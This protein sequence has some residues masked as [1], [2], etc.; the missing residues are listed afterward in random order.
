MYY[1]R[2]SRTP[3]LRTAKHLTRKKSG[4]SQKREWSSFIGWC[5]TK[6]VRSSYG[7]T[8]DSHLVYP[9]P[10]PQC[11]GGLGQSPVVIRFN[12]DFGGIGL[13][14]YENPIHNRPKTTTK[15]NLGAL[16][17][18]FKRSATHEGFSSL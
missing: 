14:R 10:L 17:H 9:Y 8:D 11:L 3:N 4:G 15:T 1:A 6:P 13:I 2:I 5:L 16:K 7:L 18:I 12:R